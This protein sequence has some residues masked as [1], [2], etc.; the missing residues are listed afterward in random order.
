MLYAFNGLLPEIFTAMITAAYF[1]V[2]FVNNL[3][4]DFVYYEVLSLIGRRHGLH[5]E[6]RRNL[7]GVLVR[8]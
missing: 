1:I 6:E 4:N 7:A 8:G 5:C 3:L 2:E